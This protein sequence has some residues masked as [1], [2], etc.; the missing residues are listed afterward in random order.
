MNDLQV[1]LTEYLQEHVSLTCLQYSLNLEVSLG[2]RS[3]LIQT[4][5]QLNLLFLLRT[6]P[7]HYECVLSTLKY[8]LFS[9]SGNLVKLTLL[10]IYL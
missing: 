9:F 10:T 2:W 3:T 4:I 6:M 8:S 5:S 1:L 7:C